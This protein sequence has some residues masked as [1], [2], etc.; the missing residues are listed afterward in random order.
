MLAAPQELVGHRGADGLQQP[1]GSRSRCAAPGRPR[2]AP[3]S[4]GRGARGAAPHPLRRGVRGLRGTGGRSGH[5]GS[6]GGRAGGRASERVGAGAA[7]RAMCTGEGRG[8]AEPRGS[9]SDAHP[10]A[11]GEGTPRRPTSNGSTAPRRSAGR[12]R[13]SPRRAHGRRRRRPGHRADRALAR[14]PRL[15][16]PR[17]GSPARH[18]SATTGSAGTLASEE[19]KGPRGASRCA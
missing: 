10:A 19:R 11:E 15:L 5:G 18:D 9:P 14:F 2:P 8:G 17:G 1:T 12:S 16:S 13:Q 7:V 3:G 4:G 6:A